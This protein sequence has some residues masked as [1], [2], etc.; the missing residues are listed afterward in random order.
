MMAVVCTLLW[1]IPVKSHTTALL[2]DGPIVRMNR[3]RMAVQRDPVRC[4]SD[5]AAQKTLFWDLSVQH[6]CC[7]V[8]KWRSPH[9]ASLQWLV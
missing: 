2:P 1:F 4:T 9:P 6:R 5:R 7:N 8:R 3:L